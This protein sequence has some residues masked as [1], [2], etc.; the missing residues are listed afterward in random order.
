MTSRAEI[1][2][3]IKTRKAGYTADVNNILSNYGTERETVK[4][5]NGRQLLELLQNADDAR[6][7]QVLIKLD[8]NQNTLVISNKG[9]ECNPFSVEGVESIMYANLS[10]KSNGRYIGNKGLGFRSIINWA[11]EIS[12]LTNNIKLNFSQRSSENIYKDLVTKEERE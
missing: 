4:E 1:E 6:S 3:L 5:Y 10:S 8:T 12:I 7:Q 9:K 2:K 11:D